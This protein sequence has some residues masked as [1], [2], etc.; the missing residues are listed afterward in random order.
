MIHDQSH[1]LSGQNG[2]N[3]FHLLT[4]ITPR[5]RTNFSH[6]RIGSPPP[7]SSPR[8]RTKMA[9]AQKTGTKMGCP[10]KWK[11]GPKAACLP[12]LLNFEHPNDPECP[13][14]SSESCAAAWAQQLA[15]SPK[16]S[17]ISS[18]LWELGARG[19]APGNAPGGVSGSPG[20]LHSS[21]FL[22]FPRFPR[23]P[24]LFFLLLD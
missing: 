7:L 13:A 23:F 5:N 18:K 12:L 10:G 2:N 17:G 21:G 24:Q 20:F 14:T 4:L 19:L 9:V 11:L 8:N 3:R 22:R 15:S 16:A 6:P 1:P